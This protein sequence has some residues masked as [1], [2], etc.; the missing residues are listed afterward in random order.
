MRV[1]T[2]YYSPSLDDTK[3]SLNDDFKQLETLMRL[4]ALHDCIVLLRQEYENTYELWSK[5]Y[6]NK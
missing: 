4:D 2:L 5:H 1:A 3:I 6:A